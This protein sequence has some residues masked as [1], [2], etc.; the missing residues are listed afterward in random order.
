MDLLPARGTVVLDAASQ[1]D[2]VQWLDPVNVRL[3]D[4]SGAAVSVGANHMAARG[5]IRRLAPAGWD[6]GVPLG[7]HAAARLSS[8]LALLAA[9]LREPSLTWVTPVDPLFAAENKVVQY[10]AALTAGVRI[11]ATAMSGS[12]GDLV[13]ELGDSFVLKPLGPGHFQEP[14]GSS[15]VLY[16][17]KVPAAELA[18]IDLL[19][20]P[21]LAQE[22]VAAETHLRIVTV[23][24]RAWT[25]ALDATGLPID[26]REHESAH[27][28]FRATDRWPQVEEAALRLAAG[29]G[30]GY[31]SQDWLIDRD[32]PVFLDLNPGGQWMFLPE[33]IAT[34]VAQA[35]A[36]WLAGR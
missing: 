22:V 15:Q 1:S 3:V 19:D 4:I 33:P 31:S 14:D 29:L 2:V 9:I 26:W 13:E 12:P 35:L 34:S 5:W 17:K 36:A 7:S 16:V 18:G 25:A 10:R 30:V 28:T 8:R 24:S 23:G 27:H 32:G 6:L 21:F 20:A 11:P